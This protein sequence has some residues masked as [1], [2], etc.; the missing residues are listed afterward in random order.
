VKESAPGHGRARRAL[1]RDGTRTCGVG[2][3]EGELKRVDGTADGDVQELGG[4]TS[5]A[6]TESLDGAWLC[7]L[8]IREYGVR[9]SESRRGRRDGKQARDRKAE[10]VEATESGGARLGSGGARV[11]EARGRGIYRGAGEDRPS[12]HQKVV[13]GSGRCAAVQTREMTRGQR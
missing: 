5:A 3:A 8:V 13:R 1:E 7:L 2:P 4:G 6:R 12:H 10:R 9:P 11:A